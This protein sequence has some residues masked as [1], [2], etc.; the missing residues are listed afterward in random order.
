MFVSSQ[1]L[2]TVFP[3]EQCTHIHP[4]TG[5]REKRETQ[6]IHNNKYNRTPKQYD[7]FPKEY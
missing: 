5:I 6:L 3:F 1:I 7:D 2:Q 4:E